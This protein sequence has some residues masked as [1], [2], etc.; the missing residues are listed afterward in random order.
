MS[1]TEDKIK[2]KANEAIG[3]AKRGVGDAINKAE[4]EVEGAAQQA[5]GKALGAMGDAKDKIAEYSDDKK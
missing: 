4:M 3:A 5:K 1:G 2:G